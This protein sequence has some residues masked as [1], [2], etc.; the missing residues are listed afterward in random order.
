MG[1]RPAGLDH[2]NIF[3]RDAE[4]SHR[5]YTEIFG[6]HTQDVSKFPGT[7]RVRG[8]FLSC[9]AG[10]AHDLA[11]F[12]VGEH[13]PLLDDS[14]FMSARWQAAGNEAVL[15]I[16]PESTHGF[17][18]FPIALARSANARVYEFLRATV[19]E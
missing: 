4:R 2:V 19:I 6:L 10:H 15:H 16:W 17:T 7:D 12:T 11:L 13:D 3:V 9:D 14:L 8:V 18:A 1:H 5:W